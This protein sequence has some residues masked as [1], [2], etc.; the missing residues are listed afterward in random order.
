MPYTTEAQEVVLQAAVEFYLKEKTDAAMEQL[1]ITFSPW[2]KKVCWHFF[3]DREFQSNLID[4]EDLTQVALLRLYQT[5]P[6]YE[7]VDP[8]VCRFTRFVYKRLKYACMNH[9]TTVARPRVKVRM[10][11]L[12]RGEGELENMDGGGR[13]H[14][15]F[16]CR[17]G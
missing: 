6:D 9:I 5:L 17:G 7:N 16:F 12:D 3:P 10:V 14:R 13:S 15:A 1:L 8:T 4:I 11:S 2:V